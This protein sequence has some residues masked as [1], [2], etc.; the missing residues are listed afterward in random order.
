MVG[1]PYAYRLAPGPSAGV[2]AVAASERGC[3]LELDDGR[4]L[5]LP[6]VPHASVARRF[7][8][9]VRRVDR[10]HIQVSGSHTSATVEGVGTRHVPFSRPISVVMACSLAALGVA[11]SVS[12]PGAARSEVA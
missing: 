9:T 2:C 1:K 7:A 4:S 12:A 11:A 5:E 6:V 10:V 3:S 8:A